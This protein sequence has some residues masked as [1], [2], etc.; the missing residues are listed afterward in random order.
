[1]PGI[2]YHC[3][4]NCAFPEASQFPGAVLRTS[5]HPRN[6]WLLYPRQ[7]IKLDTFP[8]QK[9]R[10]VTAPPASSP[11]AALA[12]W[13]GVSNESCFEQPSLALPALPPAVLAQ[14]KS[15]DPG[16]HSGYGA[17]PAV[18][19][20]SYHFSL[21]FS[22]TPQNMVCGHTRPALLTPKLKPRLGYEQV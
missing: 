3:S 9:R 20:F 22:P 5:L 13:P 10:A 17:S 7:T 14:L 11:T 4:N 15:S 12:A 6:Y 18:H 16:P 8:L 19:P 21:L 2:R 1:M